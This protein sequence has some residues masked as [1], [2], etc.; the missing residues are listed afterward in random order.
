MATRRSSAFSSDLAELDA[1]ANLPQPRPHH[2]D[3]Q[4][5]T[6]PLGS[7]ATPSPAGLGGAPSSSRPTV[8]TS[9]LGVSVDIGGGQATLHAPHVL[10]KPTEQPAARVVSRPPR[11]ASRTTPTTST[12]QSAEASQAGRSEAVTSVVRSALPEPPAPAGV[13]VAS[14]VESSAINPPVHRTQVRLPEDL[15][16]WLTAQASSRSRTLGTVVALAARDF[17]H[18]LSLEAPSVDGLEVP[19]HAS[20]G[21]TIPVSLRFTPAQLGLLDEL[22]AGGRVTRSAVVVAALRAAIAAVPRG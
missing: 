15:L 13:A 19:R 3:T 6:P 16:R 14:A 7:L 17:S 5:S 9:D 2:P 4:T 8:E 22:A 20:L 1:L 12:L 21:P 18:S 10:E 11:R